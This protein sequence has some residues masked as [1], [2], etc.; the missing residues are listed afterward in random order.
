[1]IETPDFYDHVPKPFHII[2]VDG[3]G[4]VLEAGPDCKYF[5]PGDEV[6][7]GSVPI[8]NGSA[9][10][11]Q[12][13][14]ERMA[15]RKPSSFDFVE[16]AALPVT[17]GTAYEA[18]IEH[19]GIKKNEQAAILIINGAG[20]KKHL[21][22]RPMSNSVAY[23]ETRELTQ[24]CFETGVGSMASQIA[25]NILN[26]PVVI[27][28]ASRSDTVEWTKK[29]GATHVLNHR[30]DLKTQIDALNLQVPLKWV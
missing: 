28:T 2:G 29:M 20:G 23:C 22:R 6:F 26:L 21:R 4:V 14:D 18:L 30:L 5:K 27:T 1:M 3:A 19:L 10:E 17:Y 7:Y 12:L 11:R 9:A 13:A 24:S 15:G 16:A 8:R 25:R